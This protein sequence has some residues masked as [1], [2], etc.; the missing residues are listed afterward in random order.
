MSKKNPARKS[1]PASNQEAIARLTIIDIAAQLDL[2][3]TYVRT[4]I[5][6]GQLETELVPL[7]EGSKTNQHVA[8]P[9]AVA[10][11]RANLNARHTTRADGRNK[12]T[13]YATVEELDQLNAWKASAKVEVIIEKP[14]YGKAKQADAVAAE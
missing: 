9:E 12:Y 14:V 3:T 1:T 5:R 11:W 2:S 10:T 6:K 7:K 4:A 8:T 13:L